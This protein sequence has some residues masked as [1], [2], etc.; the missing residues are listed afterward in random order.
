[1]NYLD[2]IISSQ[3]FSLIKIQII[4]PIQVATFPSLD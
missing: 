4:P 3:L 1:M 2:N